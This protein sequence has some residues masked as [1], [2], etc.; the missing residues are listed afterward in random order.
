VDDK[1]QAKDIRTGRS[2]LEDNLK[3]FIVHQGD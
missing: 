3:L 2:K 1:G